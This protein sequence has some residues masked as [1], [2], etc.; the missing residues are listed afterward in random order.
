MKTRKL[1]WCKIAEKK[2]P[3]G[4]YQTQLI[5]GWRLFIPQRMQQ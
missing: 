3:A 5:E 4:Q 2:T 1:E